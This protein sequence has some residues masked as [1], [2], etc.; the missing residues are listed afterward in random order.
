MSVATSGTSTSTLLKL[1][2]SY[3]GRRKNRYMAQ[4]LTEFEETLEPVLRRQGKA[5]E[6]EAFK[7]FI[8]QKMHALVVDM[9]Q[10]LNLKPGE[11]I[12]AL[13]LELRDRIFSR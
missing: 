9:G 1:I 8:R 6:A 2:R 13:A 12:N 3:L 4:I 5:Q 10:V 7:G 11:E